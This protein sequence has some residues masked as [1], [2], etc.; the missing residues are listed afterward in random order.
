MVDTICKRPL[1]FASAMSV[2]FCLACTYLSAVGM[3]ALCASA[4]L[5]FLFL[6]PFRSR[7][8]K[9]AL[10]ALILCVVMTL[11]SAARYLFLYLP[12]CDYTGR[13]VT[14][15]G[16]VVS[17][18]ED[19]VDIRC[20]SV[21]AD[22]KTE[23][24]MFKASLAYSGN[25]PLFP[26]SRVNMKVRFYDTAYRASSDG[27]VIYGEVTDTEI[28]RNFS[29]SSP[30]YILYKLR[31][32]VMSA[33]PFKSP[34]TLAFVKGMIFGDKTDI[35]GKLT[36]MMNT[37]GMSH[38][39]AV[40]GLHLVFA[41]VLVD[42]V[43]SLFSVGYRFRAVLAI[44]AVVAFTVFSGFAVS[45]IRAAIMTSVYYVGRVI[46]KVPDSL[47]SLAAS[48][49]AIL[50][51]AP[52]N[53][54]SLSFILSAAATFG[55]I[56]LMPCLNSLVKLDIKNGILRG[57]YYTVTGLFNMSLSATLVCL[58]ITAFTFG[59]FCVISPLVN[60][61]MTLPM[62]LVFYIGALSLVFSFV[63]WLSPLFSFVGDALYS[64]IE[65]IV[66][67]CFFLKNITVSG[68]YR[69]FYLVVVLLLVL[70]VGIYV[71]YKKQL[72]ARFAFWYISGYASLCIVLFVINAV[73][74]VGRVNVDFVD[75]G[76]GNCTVISRDET[77]VI[78][79]CGGSDTSNILDVLNGNSVKRISCIALT[80]MDSDHV[81]YLQQLV[82]TYIVEEIMYP[83]FTDVSD[84]QAVFDAAEKSGT[85][86]TV[87]QH[88]VK[89]E[90]LAGTTI[91]CYVERAEPVKHTDN[92]SAVYKLEVGESTVLFT[93]DMNIYQEYSYLGY[94]DELDADIL[95]VAHHGS[96]TSSH[97]KFLELC[98]PEYSVISVGVDNINGHPDAAVLKRL[99]SVSTVLKTSESSTIT[100]Q[101]TDRGYKCLNE[102]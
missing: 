31:D 87:L 48:S 100:F 76:Q 95:L 60:V 52:Y 50:V 42:F 38:F 62:Q 17:V 90:P 22:G 13:E 83:H 86:L 69:Y 89:T 65:F 53:I 91:S 7:L 45:C 85:R 4:V 93:G 33:L 79:E 23:K 58:P 46:G 82:D 19:G 3:L 40:S 18:Y 41:V 11:S 74:S 2:A 72:T 61:L 49:Y 21:M 94:G 67:K 47:T 16:E 99:E 36:N 98:S 8:I 20:S 70:V 84:M 56:I 34:E 57:I 63:P 101:F 39:M 35:S 24:V 6:L 77:A 28:L 12:V 26:S 97:K 54:C 5:A 15:T 64:I 1:F 25:A 73:S 10:L 88:D 29:L 80:H 32:N 51:F 9:P 66:T 92:L 55:I 43:L 81:S 30:R 59:Q 78:I 71:L 68:S 14:V 96:K 37:L 44:V 75:V 102:R 27:T